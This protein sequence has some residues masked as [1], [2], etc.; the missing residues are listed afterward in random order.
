MVLLEPECNHLYLFGK[1]RLGC[2]ARSAQIALQLLSNRENFFLREELP[3]LGTAD[4][5]RDWQ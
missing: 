5:E 4:M 2:M 3:T 1:T